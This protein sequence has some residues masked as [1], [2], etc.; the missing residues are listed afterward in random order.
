MNLKT[1]NI[2]GMEKRARAAF[3]NSLSGFKSAN[4]IGTRDEQGVTNLAIMSSLTHLGSHPPLF[5]LV[6]RPGG[7]E[8]HTLKNILATG[9][10]TVNHVT[11]EIIEQAHQTAARY[12]AGESEFDATGLNPVWQEGF[13][14]PMVQEAN[15]RLGLKL[16]QH[17]RLEVN[18]THL[19]IGEVVLACVPEIACR[20]DSSLDLGAA[21][22][23]AL[24]G[25]DTYHTGGEEKRMA[26]AKP[27]L[28]PRQIDE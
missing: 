6:I 13:L 14:A 12:A 4:L 18:D 8:R 7:D 3:V 20:A 5:S 26:Y 11:A 15:V 1:I 25:L 16:R 28:P 27:D 9:F 17:M 21:G 2:A 24:S 23:V 10:F 19:V 22:S